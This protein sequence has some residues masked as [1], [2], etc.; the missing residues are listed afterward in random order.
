MELLE[1]NQDIVFTVNIKTEMSDKKIL[2]M[3]IRT[4]SYHIIS[5]PQTSASPRENMAAG[6]HE[7]MFTIERE[8]VREKYAASES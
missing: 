1:Q 3:T 7:T 4:F 6:S 2:L 5:V 8:R